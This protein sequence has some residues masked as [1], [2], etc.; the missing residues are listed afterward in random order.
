MPPKLT[1]YFDARPDTWT[2]VGVNCCPPWM[3]LEDCSKFN[4]IGPHR[5]DVDDDDDWDKNGDDDN[6]DSEWP[7]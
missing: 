1:S 3:S 2:C 6:D 7:S 5:E 4:G